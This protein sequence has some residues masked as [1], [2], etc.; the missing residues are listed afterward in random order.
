MLNPSSF[1]CDPELTCGSIPKPSLSVLLSLPFRE[2]LLAADDPLLSGNIVRK[3]VGAPA[4]RKLHTI[5]SNLYTDQHWSIATGIQNEQT[6][7]FS[8]HDDLGI[9]DHSAI[10]GLVVVRLLIV[11]NDPDFESLSLTL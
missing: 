2:R 4:D 6:C 7:T 11:P 8:V 1:G 9:I 5:V 3:I 10:A